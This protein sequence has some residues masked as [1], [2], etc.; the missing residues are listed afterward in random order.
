MITQVFAQNTSPDE[1]S[2]LVFLLVVFFSLLLSIL[3]LGLIKK[4]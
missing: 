1:S 2:L 4:R 3:F